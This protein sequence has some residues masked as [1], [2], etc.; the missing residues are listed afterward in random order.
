MVIRMHRC[1]GAIDGTM[2]VTV[3]YL[4]TYLRHIA[5]GIGGLSKACSKYGTS[6]ENSHL[7]IQGERTEH[8]LMYYSM[9]WV[10]QKPNFHGCQ[11][12][13]LQYNLIFL[14]NTFYMIFDNEFV[15]NWF[16]R[17][18]EFTS[19]FYPVNLMFSCNL[20]FMLLYPRERYHQS[21][22]HIQRSFWGIKTIFQLP[23]YLHL[24]CHWMHIWHFERMV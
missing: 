8:M 16:Y 2:I 10:N 13:N 24:Q 5:I 1:L 18:N 6:M 22:C 23:T 3:A 7:C 20:G 9:Y 12:L 11:N 17:S 4:L 15:I 19:F 21:D 14:L